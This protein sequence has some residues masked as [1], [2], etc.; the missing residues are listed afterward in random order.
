[1]LHSTNTNIQM[2]V[3][4][5]Q[6]CRSEYHQC[7]RN[8][9]SKKNAKIIVHRVIN[10][11]VPRR[12]ETRRNYVLKSERDKQ[13]SLDMSWGE[14]DWKNIITTGMINGKQSGGRQRVKH[15]DSLKMWL[16][17]ENT[18]LIHTWETERSAEKWLPMPPGRALEEEGFSCRE[19]KR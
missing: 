16:Q 6:Q 10:E 17:K 14:M 15:L 9:V 2:W 8:V 3:V 19:G 11:E 13:V 18:V 12:A 4:D 1:M 5:Y 7:S